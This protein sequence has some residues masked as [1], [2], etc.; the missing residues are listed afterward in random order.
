MYSYMFIKIFISKL[1]IDKI[2]CKIEY[3]KFSHK[4][5]LHVIAIIDYIRSDFMQYKWHGMT[6]SA[7]LH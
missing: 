7:Q 3:S 6:C 2:N 1:Q 5:L 4:S